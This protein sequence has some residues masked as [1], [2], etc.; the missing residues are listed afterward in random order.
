M[1]VE[2]ST[3]EILDRTVGFNNYPSFKAQLDN[4]STPLLYGEDLSQ[5]DKDLIF[6]GLK[7]LYAKKVLPLEVAS[8]FSHFS[9]PPLGPSDFD[10]KPMV[11]VLGQYSVGKT[12]FIRSL[13]KQDI[14][15]QRIGP[16]PT[17]DRFTAIMHTTAGQVNGRQIPGHALVM[18][19]DKPFRGLASYGNNFLTKFEGAEVCAPILNDI[20]LVD[21]P[22]VLAGEK[23]RI[24][25]DYDFSEVVRWFADRADMIIIMFDAH[26]LDISDELKEVL[27]CLKPHQEK[28]RVLL[29]KADAIDAQALL[30]VYGALMWSLGKVVQTPEVCRVYLG[31]FWDAPLKTEE[32][33]ALLEREKRDLLVEMQALSQNA[34]VRRIN[35]LVKRARSVKVHAYIIH[36]LKKQMPYVMGRS[37][38]QRRLLE[39]LDKEFL[40]CARRY[41][42]P[43]G[44]FPPVEQYRRMLAETKDISDFKRLDKSLVAEMDRVLT[45]D[46]PMLLQ[47]ATRS[48]GVGQGDMTKTAAEKYRQQLY[49]QQYPEQHFPSG[50]QSEAAAL[51]TAPPTPPVFPYQQ[52]QPQQQPQQQLL[53][54]DNRHDGHTYQSRYPP[55]VFPETGNQ[56]GVR[57]AG[58]FFA[59]GAIPVLSDQRE[60]A[61]QTA[62][63]APLTTNRRQHWEQ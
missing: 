14:P 12:S 31:S 60:G 52:Q 39:R 20:T 3:P 47:R 16:E 34:V 43:L 57:L 15:G 48:N 44:D 58:S 59:E 24:G 56:R 33:R 46:I 62:S 49:Q 5:V 8:K 32:S 10:A 37:E 22:G 7:Q 55:G 9:S 35:E 21:T 28:V 19:T 23:Q 41:N 63:E 2:E 29:N 30:R 26:K 51:F 13:L 36:Y 27:D 11:L 38:K 61:D 54:H 40:A 53:F 6:E 42:L 50:V 17:T 1:Y 18:Q 25:R 4:T 45:H